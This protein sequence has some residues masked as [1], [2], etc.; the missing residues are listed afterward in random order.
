M[1][2]VISGTATGD[3]THIGFV[4]SPCRSDNSRNQPCLAFGWQ[5][6]AFPVVTWQKDD[7]QSHEARLID[8]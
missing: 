5:W 7:K 6:S 3:K 1:Q 4:A 2:L 8:L